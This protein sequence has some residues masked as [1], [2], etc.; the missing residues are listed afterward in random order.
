MAR[1]EGE[2]IAARKPVSHFILV[3]KH[4]TFWQEM[5]FSTVPFQDQIVKLTN[6]AAKYQMLS[7]SHRKML[8]TLQYSFKDIGIIALMSP[9]NQ[10]IQKGTPK[11]FIVISSLFIYFDRGEPW[12][13]DKLIFHVTYRSHV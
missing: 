5:S 12:S 10:R 3:R 9:V 11:T 6:F 8:L 1:G 13:N 7:T 4:S 2:G